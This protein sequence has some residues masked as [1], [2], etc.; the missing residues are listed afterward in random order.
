MIAWCLQYGRSER[1]RK[2]TISLVRMNESIVV[3]IWHCTLPQP[4]GPTTRTPNLLIVIEFGVWR[5]SLVKVG[6]NNG[7]VMITAEAQA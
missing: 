7:V 4:A 3:D 2:L 6:R 5:G 1:Y